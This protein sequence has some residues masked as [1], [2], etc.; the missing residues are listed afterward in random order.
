[1]T[2]W[3]PG[4]SVLLPSKHLKVLISQKMPKVSIRTLCTKD[5]NGQWQNDTTCFF[6]WSPFL[7]WEVPLSSWQIYENLTL[8]CETWWTPP[9]AGLHRDLPE[10]E[11]FVGEE[12]T[13]IH[14]P[15][16]PAPRRR[17]QTRVATYCNTLQ[18]DQYAPFLAATRMSGMSQGVLS[19]VFC[20]LTISNFDFLLVPHGM[21]HIQTQ[22]H[23]VLL[24]KKVGQLRTVH[25][26]KLCTNCR[27]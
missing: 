25:R 3:E 4:L 1:M 5:K 20:S 7:A 22:F 13:I 15:A 10:L 21:R 11:M 18:P 24:L 17:D 14:A 2:L 6:F 23:N 26:F 16:T 9:W 27:S 8:T 19:P 12:S